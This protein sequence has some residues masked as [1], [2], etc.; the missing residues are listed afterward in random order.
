M[1]VI[2]KKNVE[3]PDFYLSMRSD[4]YAE[5]MFHRRVGRR[6][7]ERKRIGDDRARTLFVVPLQKTRA[8]DFKVDLG[9]K[10][11]GLIGKPGLHVHR[12][13]FTEGLLAEGNPSR[14]LARFRRCFFGSIPFFFVARFL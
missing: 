5:L 6:N 11:A 4:R 7:I 3:V 14:G 8:K 2:D 12:I 10:V 13:I 9:K 1:I